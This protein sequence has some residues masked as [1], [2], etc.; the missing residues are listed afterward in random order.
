MTHMEV[1]SNLAEKGSHLQMPTEL[2]IKDLDQ[3]SVNM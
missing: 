1:A 2:G 3:G